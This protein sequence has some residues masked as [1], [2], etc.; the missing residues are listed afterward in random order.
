MD[1]IKKQY[2]EDIYRTK[3]TTNEVSWYQDNP[4]TSVDLIL[5]FG[6]DKSDK[7]IDIGGGDSN[8]ADK[9]LRL[10]FEN[11]FVLDISGKALEK[12]KMKL[13]DKAK[14][15]TWIEADIL[16]FET[17]TRFDI[18]HDRATF[19]F[20]TK[21]EDI[22]SYVEVAHKFIKPKKYL[23]IS[24]FS[25]NGP[26]KCSGLDITQYSE[27]SIKKTF[28]KEFNHIKSFK[29]I[30]ITP[31]HKKQIFLWNVFRRSK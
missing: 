17:N 13:R 8:L 19:H 11:L 30:H 25:I 7:I 3:D 20:L 5:S 10:N 29:K 22:V 24:T 26:K 4:Q 14:L 27:D 12:A 23:I 6:V 28:G 9:L 2:W 15:V 31:F 1:G 16:E 21:K 18:W